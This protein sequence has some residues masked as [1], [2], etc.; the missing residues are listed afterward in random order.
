MK[1]ASEAAEFSVYRTWGEGFPQWFY[2]SPLEQLATTAVVDSSTGIFFLSNRI[3]I[4]IFMID[5]RFSTRV[6]FPAVQSQRTTCAL[7]QYNTKA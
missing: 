5:I 1:S 3:R 4:M 6:R 2:C 7:E